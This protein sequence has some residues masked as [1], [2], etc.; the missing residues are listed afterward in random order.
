MAKGLIDGMASSHQDDDDRHSTDD[1]ESPATSSISEEDQAGVRNIEAVSQTWTR[2][3]LIVAYV[4]YSTLMTSCFCLGG[5]ANISQH[6]LGCILHVSGEPNHFES[7]RLRDQRL[8]K[9]LP[10]RYRPGGTTSRQW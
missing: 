8:C 3:S 1:A 2:W 10:S 5:T 4:G 6:L 9:A 7:H